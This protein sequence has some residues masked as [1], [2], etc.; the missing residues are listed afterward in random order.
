M[1]LTRGTSEK[2][3]DETRQLAKSTFN[4]L[5][6]LENLLCC[7]HVH[8]VGR[9]HCGAVPQLGFSTFVLAQVRGGING[10]K[11]EGAPARRW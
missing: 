11:A 4:L 6:R 10:R 2:G 9:H 7:S 3:H 8:Q 1:T 5:A